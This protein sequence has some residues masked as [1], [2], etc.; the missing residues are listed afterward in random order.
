MLTDGHKWW[1][2]TGPSTGGDTCSREV[3][4]S[5]RYPVTLA[6]QDYDER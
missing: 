5:G 6:G 1:Q 2:P 4:S 3:E